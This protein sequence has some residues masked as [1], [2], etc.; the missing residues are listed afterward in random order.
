MRP[1]KGSESLKANRKIMRTTINEVKKKRSRRWFN[2]TWQKHGLEK[3]QRKHRG[4]R[5]GAKFQGTI[6]PDKAI[7]SYCINIFNDNAMSHFRNN[8]KRRQ[9][10]LIGQK[11]IETEASESQAVEWCLNKKRRNPRVMFL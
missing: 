11:F 6:R 9:R 1:K 8:L 3:Q 2:V 5:R 10:N 7:A 4:I